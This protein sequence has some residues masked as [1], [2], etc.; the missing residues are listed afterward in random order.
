[1]P[2]ACPPRQSKSLSRANPASLSGRLDHPLGGIGLDGCSREPGAGTDRDHVKST[3]RPHRD[4]VAVRWQPCRRGEARSLGTGCA[5]LPPSSRQAVLARSVTSLANRSALSRSWDRSAR[6]ASG[7]AARTMSCVP[8]V[9][10]DRRYAE[11]SATSGWWWRSA[12]GGI[13]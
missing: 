1:M 7:M 3:W 9:E 12:K 10:R 2:S 5:G 13:T 8:S 6:D 4:P 11:W